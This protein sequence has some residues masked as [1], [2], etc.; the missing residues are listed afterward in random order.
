MHY[1]LKQ[2]GTNKIT[3]YF[4]N[5]TLDIMIHHLFTFLLLN[6]LFFAIGAPGF[7][8]S[9]YRTTISYLHPINNDSHFLIFYA[10]IGLVVPIAI[11]KIVSRI[12]CRLKKIR[13]N[14][15]EIPVSISFWYPIS[16]LVGFS[17]FSI[18]VSNPLGYPCQ[19]S[20]I[21]FPMRLSLI[22]VIVVFS[23]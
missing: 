9:E 7:N 23:S 14:L 1:P 2:V 21:H 5:H 17:S 11:A 8:V 3:S 19:Y 22:V 18:S 10:L 16:Y 6:T 12:K 15:R 13:R 20:H 4:G